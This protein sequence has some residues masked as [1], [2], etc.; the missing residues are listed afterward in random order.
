MNVDESITF[1]YSHE[2]QQARFSIGHDGQTLSVEANRL[3]DVNAANTE[4]GPWLLTVPPHQHLDVAGVK[5]LVF[6]IE[7]AHA[8]MVEKNAELE[9]HASDG[10]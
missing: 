1:D 6:L 4:A 8:W 7:Q 10:S 5:Q 2:F 9:G 3:M